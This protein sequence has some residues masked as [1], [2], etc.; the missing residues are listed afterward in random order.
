MQ[1]ELTAQN[2]QQLEWEQRDPEWQGKTLEDVANAILQ[3]YF[4]QRMLQGLQLAV[5]YVRQGESHE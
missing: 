2:Q 3:R 5:Q 4:A 1:I